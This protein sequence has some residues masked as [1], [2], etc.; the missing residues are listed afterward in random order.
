MKNFTLALLALL[1]LSVVEAQPSRQGQ[2]G[3]LTGQWKLVGWT[4][5]NFVPIKGKL[6]TVLF[7]GDQITGFSGCNRFIG[8]Y[9]LERGTLK[10]SRLASTRQACAPAVMQQEAAFL[11]AVSGQ[12]LRVEQLADSLTLTTPGGSML[13]FRRST[14]QPRP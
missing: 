11:E 6:P 8:L 10:V 4:L 5:P 7:R 9:T 14:A 12:S 3:E 13:S 1:T 2:P